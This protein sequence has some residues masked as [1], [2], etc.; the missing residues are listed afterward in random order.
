MATVIV[1]EGLEM[2][3]AELEEH[4]VFL[5]ELRESGITNM[6]G[7]GPYLQETRDLDAH[8]ARKV[9]VYWMETFSQRH[10]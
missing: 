5:D 10:K 9:L 1:S 8:T 4:L 2:E 3:E 7:A 6:F